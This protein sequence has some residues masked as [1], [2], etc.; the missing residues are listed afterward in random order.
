MAG[1]REGSKMA[2]LALLIDNW[3]FYDPRLTMMK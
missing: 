1:M 3:P 2:K